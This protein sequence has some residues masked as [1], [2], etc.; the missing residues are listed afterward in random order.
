LEEMIQEDKSKGYLP[1]M[2]VGT[3]G[4]V[5]T[6]AVDD[7]STISEICKLNNL[8]FHLDGAYGL[9]AAAVPR[10]KQMF[11]GLH[12]V[13]SFAL[14]PHKWLYNA[15]EVGCVVVKNPQD[16][17]HTFSSNPEYYNFHQV[18]DAAHNFYEYGFQNSRGFRA[19]K[20]WV[21]I[22]HVGKQGFIEM[23]STNIEQAIVL[24]QEAELHPELQAIS[25][26]LS[27]TN[28]RYVPSG[29][30]LQ[31]V[32]ANTYLN[33]LNKELL[34]S[35]QKGGEVFL[36]NAII[37]NKYCLRSCIVNFRT[38]IKDIIEIIAIVVR[39]GRKVNNRLSVK[40]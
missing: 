22:Q 1:I 26:N 10:M 8:W 20:L 28:F 14:D 16:L 34:D 15:L 23:I 31:Q 13:D 29:F 33:S 36:S 32:G 25:Q 18:F 19:F 27:I 12:G 24:F 21:N 37:D 7:I 35:L 6:G 11:M 30:D 4:D 38:S 39:E 3:A 2:V 5:S 17:L 40:E 9:P